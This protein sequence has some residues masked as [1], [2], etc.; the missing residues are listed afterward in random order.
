MEC[1]TLR[2]PPLVLVLIFT[3]FLFVLAS[4]ADCSLKQTAECSFQFHYQPYTRGDRDSSVGI[5]TR[6]RLDGPGI[7]FRCRRDFPHSS[8]L[9]LGPTQPPIQCVPG[10]FPEGKAAW[11]WR[12]FGH[13]PPSSAEVK[14]RVD[15][16]LKRGSSESKHKYLMLLSLFKLTSYSWIWLDWHS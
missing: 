12:G 13:P 8:R 4:I 3:I 9:S 16:Q 5:A 7:E 6:Y 2:S 1:F 11:A 15:L 10:L 14:E